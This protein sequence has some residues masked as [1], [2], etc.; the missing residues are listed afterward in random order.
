MFLAVDRL[1]ANSFDTWKVMSGPALPAAPFAG[2]ALQQKRCTRKQ[3]MIFGMLLNAVFTAS[4]GLLEF[5]DMGED[6]QGGVGKDK[7]KGKGVYLYLAV[8]YGSRIL[9]GVGCGLLDTSLYALIAAMFAGH[10]VGRGSLTP[11]LPRLDPGL[12]PG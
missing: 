4:F 6:E 8:A 12:I 1:K 3:M 11:C 10:K 9:A 5:V 7:G 2:I